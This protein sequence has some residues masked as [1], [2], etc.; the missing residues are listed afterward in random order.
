MASGDRLNDLAPAHRPSSRPPQAHQVHV[1]GEQDRASTD[2]PAP[3]AIPL[4]EIDWSFGASTQRGLT[5]GLH[6]WP[7]RF[8]PD[9]PRAAILEL[10]APGDLVID[11][12]C[13]SGTT[14]VEALANGRRAFSADINP[15]AA[16]VTAGKCETP[17]ARERRLLA[18]WVQQLIVTSPTVDMIG[19]APPI[20]NI[21]YWFDDEVI[22][23]LVYLRTELR[24]LGIARAFLETIFS[25]IIVSVSRQE[26][27][28]RYRRVEKLVDGQ[29][30][31]DQFRR[32]LIRGLGMA[33]ELDRVRGATSSEVIVADAR[34]LATAS[35]L[36]G[37]RLACF[38][39]PY[40]NTFDYHLYHRF[41][42]FWLDMDPRQVKSSEIGA[43]LRYQADGSTW[44][45]DMT[46]A[47]RSLRE[48][49]APGGRVLCVVGS[50]KYNGIVLDSARSLIDAV[51][52]I[53]FTLEMERTRQVA[54]HRKS[55]NLSDARLVEEQVLL[56]R[57]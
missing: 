30:T 51:T 2:G 46:Q 47:F 26:S 38:S 1:W 11:P 45:L 18:E 9:I 35:H 29:V 54:S 25:S 49:L 22:S 37:A 16:L 39:P 15:L 12:F 13:G 23:E 44:A 31:L 55:F 33:D 50:G 28:T 3:S 24:A 17:N 42:M 10:T 19:A 5:H 27:E 53:G 40:P 57:S 7:G 43:H 14:A 21:S 36:R 34:E 41:R 48:L 4:E 20:P 6:P 56:F 32:R 52:P 8:I